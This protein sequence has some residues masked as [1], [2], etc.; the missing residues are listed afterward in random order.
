[1][2]HCLFRSFHGSRAQ[3]AAFQAR[4]G[5]G[6]DTRGNVI[7]SDV[8]AISI[9]VERTGINAIGFGVADE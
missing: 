3:I 7:S 4:R 5:S 6:A 8:L 1:V 2:D 9:F